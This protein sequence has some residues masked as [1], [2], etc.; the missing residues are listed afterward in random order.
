VLYLDILS[1]L[2]IIR[3]RIDK[4]LQESLKDVGINI[5]C[6]H[7]WLL[8]LVYNNGGE[9]EIKS[10]V[11][12]LEKKKTTISEMVVTLEKRG[13]LEKYQSSYD[14][15]IYCVKATEK[16]EL[17]KDDIQDVINKIASKV[18]LDIK[19]E[20]IS[21]TARTIQKMVDNLG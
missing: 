1:S 7:V 4:E 2:G 5:S 21:I 11:S 14:K 15:R 6:G 13:L 19:D 3:Q 8:S 17:L 9:I 20:D 16:A 10:L 12:A 18:M